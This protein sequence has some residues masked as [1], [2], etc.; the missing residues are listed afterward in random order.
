[1]TDNQAAV[2]GAANDKEAQIV[3][4]AMASSA[5]NDS[6]SL[7]S[8]GGRSLRV[9]MTMKLL[10]VV[11]VSLIGFGSHWSSGVT[12]AMKSTLKKKLHINNAEYALLDASEDFIK[13]ALIVGTGLVTD[14]IG[15]AHAL[16]WGNSL[17]SVGAILVAAATTVRSYRFMIGGIVVQAIGD[18]TT[19]VAQYKVFSSWFAPSDG[20]ASTLGFELG[21]GKI[22]S[23]VGQATANVIA[24]RLGDFSWV[25]WMA[26]VMNVFT[27]IVTVG[28]FYFTRWC[29]RRYGDLADPATGERLTENNKSFELKKVCALPWPFWAVMAFS[30]FETSTA[31]VFSGNATELAE[32]RFHIDSVKAGWYAALSKYTGFFLVPVLG[33]VIDRFGQRL[34]I[35]LVCGAFMF[36]AMALVAWGETVSGTA[37]SFGVYAVALSLGP[38]T[39]IDSTRTSMWYPEVFGSAYGIK[40]GLNNAMNIIIR[41]VTGVIQDQD[42]DSYDRVVIVYAVLAAASLVVG[43]SLVILGRFSID[44][45]RLQWSRI[46]RMAKGHTIGERRELFETGKNARRHRLFSQSCLVAAISLIVGSW[47]AY[48]W[49]VATGNND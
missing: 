15:G 36:T 9:P 6:A 24:R 39:I 40:I 41:I 28:F 22:G 3:T 27:N 30:L 11:L 38:T 13:S 18:V 21:L 16:L 35:M 37:A 4:T 33:F 23:F 26:V 48:F 20:F 29:G 1:M 47:I 31:I 45:G 44:L 8:A 12:G 25:Y 14:R 34:T 10:S 17:Y 7:H 42:N 19:Q 46:K 2:S 43:I 5:D 32:Q 49:G